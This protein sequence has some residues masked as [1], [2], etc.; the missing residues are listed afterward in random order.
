V[1]ALIAAATLLVTVGCLA[2]RLGHGPAGLLYLLVFALATAPGLPLGF[3]LFGRRHGAGWIAGAVLGYMLTAVALWIAIEARATSPLELAAAWGLVSLVSAALSLGRGPVLRL[4][5][6][7]PSDTAAVLVVLLIVP[8]LVGLPFDNNGARDERGNRLFRAY[9]TADFMWHMALTQ[10]LARMRLP[11]GNP[12]DAGK[13]LRYYWSYFLLPAA[14][15]ANRPVQSSF[16]LERTLEI[17]AMGAGLLFV[18]ALFLSAWAAVPRVRAAALAVVVAA[19]AASA[20]G[21]YLLYLVVRDAKSLDVLRGINVDAVTLWHFS[22]LTI[23]GLPRALW[24]T[25]QHAISC[26]LAVVGLLVVGTGGARPPLAACLLAGVFLGGAVLM[27]PF[28]GAIFAIVYGLSALVVALGSPGSRLTS[29]LRYSVAAIPVL[30]AGAACLAGEM[31][32]EGGQALTVEL[33]GL[34]RNRPLTTLGLALGP[35]LVPAL[36]SLAPPRALPPVL[37]PAVIG[38][39]T[40]LAVFF[41]VTL[42]YTDPI[43]VGWRAGQI[44]LVTMPPLIAWFFIRCRERFGRGFATIVATLVLVVGLPTTIIDAFNAQDTANHQNT[45][46]YRWTIV[47]TP[48]QQAA[49]DWIRQS[50][51]PTALV[52]MEPTIRRRDLW[53]LIP[54]LASRRMAAALPI[55]LLDMP[56]ERAAADEVSRIYRTQSV[57]E[58]WQIAT[59]YRIDYLYLDSF[60]RRMFD[61]VAI[62]KFDGALQYFSPVYRNGEVAVYAVV[63]PGA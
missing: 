21:A 37:R 39:L 24:Y 25:P 34:A 55:W 38:V 20:E 58:A 62:G 57:E 60:D 26:G 59:R 14:V 4:R 3:M 61:P 11:P 6:W 49:F 36:L 44:I 17:N 19:V 22:G 8:A 43:W 63:R 29:L 7:T 31:L 23:D 52:Q 2:W 15:T 1:R 53:S 16:D 9:F 45:T 5:A 12:Y 18:A 41:F 32:Q 13:P 54:S 10:E 48:E 50:T 51:P 46:F 28:L 40:G 35:A 42:G 56:A 30:A 47:L 33:F 27:S